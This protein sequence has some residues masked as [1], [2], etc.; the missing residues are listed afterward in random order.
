MTADNFSKT[1]HPGTLPGEMFGR[2]DR[3]PVFC[4]VTFARGRLS[5]SGVEGPK[6]NGDAIGSCGQIDMGYAHRSPVDDDNRYSSPVPADAFDY[7]PGWEAETWFTFLD[8]WR[9]WHLNDMRANCEHQTGPNWDASETLTLY[10]WRLSDNATKQ[11]REALKHAE[12]AL[13]RGETVALAPDVAAIAALPAE[14]T[15]PTDEAPGPLYGP[16]G[17][18][19]DGDT[20]NRPSETKTA[21]W[22]RPSEHPGGLL[23]KPCETCGYCYGTAWK[24][25]DVPTDVLAFLRNLPDALRV[26]AWV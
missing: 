11:V 13:R 24:S 15:T 3:V 2:T 6:R 25:E 12:K 16:N 10:H 14:V 1:L 7:A 5:I 26:P 21:G 8:V 18:R 22:V 20:Y 23:G 4:K 19:Y 9:K 17:P